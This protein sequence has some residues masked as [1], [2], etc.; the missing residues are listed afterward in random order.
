[1]HVNK[2]RKCL[3]RTYNSY[4]YSANQDTYGK[5]TG[6]TNTIGLFQKK[7][8]QGR[9]QTFLKIPLEFLGFPLYLP[10]KIPDKI[11]ASLLEIH[12]CGCVKYQW[13][14]HWITA[15]TKRFSA[16]SILKFSFL[17]LFMFYLSKICDH[18][19]MLMQIFELL[20]LFFE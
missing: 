9:L 14:A 13:K 16:I 12:N 18:N 5:I 20:L 15:K 1:M 11:E 7:S 3:Q 2:T 4:F 8:K 17:S 10:L 19:K 6:P